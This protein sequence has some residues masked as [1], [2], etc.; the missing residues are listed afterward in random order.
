MGPIGISKSQNK[1]KNYQ[2]HIIELETE[3]TQNMKQTWSTCFYDTYDF[4]SPAPLSL[5][6]T[7]PQ[8]TCDFYNLPMIPSLL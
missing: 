1:A 3:L 4:I 5:F 2:H 7:F 6:T 8:A